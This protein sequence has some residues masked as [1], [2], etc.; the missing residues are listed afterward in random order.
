MVGG[1]GSGGRGAGRWGGKHRCSCLRLERARR[2][3]LFSFSSLSHG[4]FPLSFPLCDHFFVGQAWVEGKGEL[5]T[6]RH[7]ADSGQETDC[8]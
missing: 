6:C 2:C 1:A 4:S 7:R 5:A 8:K 3:H